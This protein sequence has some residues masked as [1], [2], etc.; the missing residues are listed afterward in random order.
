MKIVSKI[1]EDAGLIR[2]AEEAC[3]NADVQKDV[4]NL[5]ERLTKG[6]GNPGISRRPI[7]NDIIEHCGKNGGRLYVRESNGII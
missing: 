7:G 3:K 4:N 6:N 2:A 1:N 5:E